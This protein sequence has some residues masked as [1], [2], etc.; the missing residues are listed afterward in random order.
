MPYVT[1]RWLGGMMTNFATIRRS[2]KKMESIEKLL[3]DDSVT[4]LT[5]KE[6]LL[7]AR[8]KQKLENVLGGIAELNRLPAAIF[9]VDINYEHIALDESR[10]LGMRTFAMVDTNSDPNLVDFPVPANDDSS[11]SIEQVVNY[12][13]GCVAEGVQQR[14]DDQAAAKKQ[15]EEQEA[16]KEA[17]K[18]EAEEAKKKAADNAAGD[19]AADA[20]AAGSTENT[21]TSGSDGTS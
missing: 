5:K 12:L 15:K 18:K 8:Q 3:K 9:L 1:E 21:D 20:D 13:G 16:A 7:M 4:S 10:K 19:E 6:R 2:V 14:K 11:K 17:A